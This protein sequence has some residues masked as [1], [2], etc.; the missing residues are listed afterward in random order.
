MPRVAAQT[1][2][3]AR[4]EGSDCMNA[5][6]ARR[7]ERGWLISCVSFQGN[8]LIA[9]GS[10]VI[11]TTRNKGEP[12][13]DPVQPAGVCAFSFYIYSSEA[14]RSTETETN[15]RQQVLHLFIKAA[16]EQRDEWRASER[17]TEAENSRLVVVQQ[18]YRG[19]P[20]NS[21]LPQPVAFPVPV[22]PPL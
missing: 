5:Y 14:A 13:D 7:R 11:R 10:G 20:I 6:S 1:H 21:E 17:E 8:Y 15:E 19:R 9:Q 12:A 3:L 16:N 2:A 18:S 4:T 22:A